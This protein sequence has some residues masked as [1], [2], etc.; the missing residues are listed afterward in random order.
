MSQGVSKGTTAILCILSAVTAFNASYMVMQYQTEARMPDYRANNAIYG[1]LGEIR[2]RVDDL[3]VGEYDIQQAVDMACVGFIT[4][5]GDRWSGYLSKEEYENYLTSLEGQASGIGVYTTYSVERNQLRIIEVYPGSGAEQ[6]GLKHGD[7]ILG[8]NGVTLEKDGY[9]AL[10]DAIGGQPGTDVQLTVLHAQTGQTETLSVQRREVQATMVTGKMLDEHTGYVRIYN[11]HKHAD[12]Q[13]EQVLDDLLEQGAQKLIFD[14][15][16]NPGGSVEVLSKMLDPLLP[17][18]TIMTLRAKDGKE[19]V[20]SSDAQALDLPMAV[21]IN[22]DSYSAAEF[23]AAALQEYDKATIVGEQT[24]G[25]GYS[26]RTYPLSDGSAL[27][28]S[29]NAYYT[30][31]GNSLIDVGVIPDIPAQLSEQAK[32]DFYFLTPVQDTQL[33]AARTALDD[34]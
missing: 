24:V 30:P 28:L 8:A 12:E 20:Y 16:S 19:E 31:K 29:D 7:Q 11:F 25:K 2:Q 22:Q 23:F 34:K 5:V 3:Y 26:Q 10:I 27:K 33:T 13:F 4:G 14:V 32:I 6:A 17:E 15:R 1:K 18:G 21:L 9:E